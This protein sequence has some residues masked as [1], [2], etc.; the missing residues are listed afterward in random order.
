VLTIE[1][2]SVVCSPPR[3]TVVYAAP[4]SGKTTVL[5]HHIIE[6]IKHG[7]RPQNIM[8]MTFTRQSAEDIKRRLKQHITNAR[9]TESVRIGT[10]H[11][12]L[13]KI[14]LETNPDIP[15]LLRPHE[16]HLLMK[17]AIHKAERS[18]F[19]RRAT[20][21]KWLLQRSLLGG[22]EFVMNTHGTAGDKVLH[23]YQKLKSKLNRWDYDD[24]LAASYA[25]LNQT[26]NLPEKLKGLRYILMDEFQDTNFV[27]WSI[28]QKMCQSGVPLF[29]VG[30]DDQS[31]YGFRGASPQWLMDFSKTYPAAGV[32]H[33]STNF[34][35]DCEIVN[36]ATR[37]I[38]HNVLRSAKQ[39]QTSSNQ[40]GHVSCWRWRDETTEQHAI[41]C[42]VR[43]LFAVKQPVSVAVLA[44]TRLQLLA[45]S[46]HMRDCPNVCFH[47]FHDA[48]GKEWDRVFIIGA[49]LDNP[50]LYNDGG[51]TA[52]SEEERRLFYVAMTRAR[53]HLEIHYPHRML[54][55][56]VTPSPFIAEA[57]LVVRN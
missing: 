49:V 40:L 34:R 3:D 32:H 27:Q 1:Q 29:V 13:F 46:E 23:A 18:L 24:I 15:V 8:A 48:K 25:L 38:E 41:V 52:I 54:G 16:Q 7:I 21:R 36:H 44:R 39:F 10:M 45:V 43:A 26:V 28:L 53:H 55:R 37:L 6:Q 9:V 47:T 31:I 22:N 20:V 30:D 19:V 12:Q 33:L 56:R 50:Y 11:A 4:G 57:G 5:I 51:V 2:Q 17:E 35:S 42:R 14:L